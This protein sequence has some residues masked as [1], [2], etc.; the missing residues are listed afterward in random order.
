[1][2]P[3]G[4]SVILRTQSETEQLM[5]PFRILQRLFFASLCAALALT[6]VAPAAADAGADTAGRVFEDVGRA[7][8]S[9]MGRGYD[10]GTADDAPSA[11]RTIEERYPVGSR[12]TVLLHHEFGAVNITSWDQRVVQCLTKV[13]AT[14]ESREAAAKAVEAVQIFAEN[15]GNTV[16]IRA[17]P[18]DADPSPG[19]WGICL[20]LE[21]SV[22]R[23]AALI[24]DER[25]ADISITGLGGDLTADVWHGDITLNEMG[26]HVDV[27]ARGRQSLT[28]S[29]LRMG[30]AFSLIDTE[31]ALSRIGGETRI[32]AS[33]ASLTV[34][35]PERGTALDITAEG[36]RVRLQF[37]EQTDPD[38]NAVVRFGTLESN[39][40]ETAAQGPVISLRHEPSGAMYRA[41]VDAAFCDVALLR[42]SAPAETRPAPKAYAGMSMFRETVSRTESAGPGTTL[43][44]EANAGSVRIEGTDAAEIAITEERTVWTVSAVDAPQALKRLDIQTRREDEKLLLTTNAQPA[45]DPVTPRVRVDLVIQCPRS[46]PVQVRTRDGVTAVAGISAPVDVQ[47]ETGRVHVSETAGDI[48]VRNTDGAAEALHC[49]GNLDIAVSEGDILVQQNAGTAALA[50]TEGKIL[51]EAPKAAVTARMKSGDV[52]ILAVDGLYGDLDVTAESGNISVALPETPD[53]DLSVTASGGVVYSAIPLTGSVSNDRQEFHVLLKDGQYRLRLEARGGDVRID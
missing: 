11:T 42:G 13:S 30:G 24:V 21:V 38:L 33:G 40:L 46:V 36:G 25:F 2:A 39:W 44:V 51:V 41:A 48:R 35:S 28:V 5:S 6:A 47:Q 32:R 15:S 12:A 50:C 8:K 23:D 34:D 9:V 7:L 4:I 20:N 43:S 53:A 45:E 31:A 27:R 37:P 22:P 29:G 26:G 3:R 1:M 52:R 17:L 49:S 19:I 16:S 10:A 14:A 18:V